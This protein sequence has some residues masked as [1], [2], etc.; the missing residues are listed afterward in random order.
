MKMC[1]DPKLDVS[2]EL[3][4]DAAPYFQ[5]IIDVLKLMIKLRRIDNNQGVIIV[6]T[7]VIIQRGAFRCSSAHHSLCRSVV[8]LKISIQSIISRNTSHC[9]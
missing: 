5:T 4:P 9:L 3:E 6:V 1:Y 2:P 8:K 7:S